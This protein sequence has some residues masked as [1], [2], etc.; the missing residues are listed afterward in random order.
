MKTVG[1]IGGIG[2]ESTIEYYRFIIA[3]Y[4]ARKGDASYP[5]IIINSIDLNRLIA[6]MNADELE[7]LRKA[8]AERDEFK[9]FAQRKQAEFEN[10]Q[11]RNQKER[12]QERKYWYT[13][14]A[15]DLLP[16]LDNLDR[17]MAAAREAGE[18]GPLVQGVAMVQTQFLELLKR[19]DRADLRAGARDREEVRDPPHGG[20]L[21]ETGR[22]GQ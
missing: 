10:Y 18:T 21:G 1:I 14:I 2:P 9:D 13:P 16:V 22:A 8:A 11:K 20:A 12:A 4:R 17:A 3:G 6:W 15:L 19:Q 7:A 5:S